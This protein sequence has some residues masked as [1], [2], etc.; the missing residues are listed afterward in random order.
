MQEYLI[1]KILDGAIIANAIIWRNMTKNEERNSKDVTNSYTEP[2]E[3]QDGTFAIP[4]PE[5]EFME[6]V[7]YDE[8][9][10]EIK[11]KEKQ[12]I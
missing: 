1:F 3:L 9:R 6:G 7:D 4:K 10:A 8:I 2:I 5:Y 11:L 12:N